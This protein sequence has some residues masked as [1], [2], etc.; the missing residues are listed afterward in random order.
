VSTATPRSRS[1]G[2]L[3]AGALILCATLAAYLPALHGGFVWDDDAHVTRPALRSLDGLRRIWFELGATQQYYPLL[4]SAF[5]VEHRLWGD[6]VAG[7]HLVNILLHAAAACLVVAIMRRLA[8]PGAWLAGFIFALHPV[9]VESVAWIS[10][11]KNTLSAV[12]CLGAAYVYIGYDGD[13]RPAR[14]AL[15]LGLFVLALLTKTVTATLPA[16]LLV[17]FCWRR[18]RLS[19][20]RDVMPLLPWLAIGAAAG[21]L[22]A[23]VERS[24]IAAEGAAPVL[25]WPGR[26]LL[27]G[28]VI[29]FY[30]GKLA[31]PADLMFV[32]PH[33]TV[34][35][36]EA[37]QYLFPAAALALVAGLWI[38]A[39][40]AQGPLR[41]AS[42]AA[43]AGFLIF[44]GT[45]FPALGFFNAFPFIYSYVADHFQYL[46]S[47][48]II[49]PASAGLALAAGRMTEESSRLLARAGAIALLA[50]LGVLTWLQSGTYRDV[51]TL[52]LATLARNPDCWMAHA[53]LGVAWSMTPGRTQDAVAEFNEALRLNPDDAEAH[54]D[55]GAVLSLMPGRQGD[56]IAQYEAAL[57][58]KPNFAGAHNNLG[59]ALAQVPGRLDEA[60]AHYEEAI[61]LEPGNAEAHNNLAS[62]WLQAPGRLEDAYAQCEEALRL[63]PGYA[64]AH[65][66]L[67][68][69]LSRM[70]GRIE[71]AV[72]QY[73]EALQLKSDYAEAH[74]NLANAWLYL[75]G[76][77]D[78]AIAQ[79]REALRLRPDLAEAHYNL[80]LALSRSPAR[81]DEAIAQ[82]GE[83]IRLRPDYAEAH[84]DLGAAL[85]TIPG[86]M[87]DAVAQYQEALRLDPG[88]APGWRNLGA[89][90]FNQGDVHG[91]VEAFREDVRLQPDSADAHFILG[92]AL[93]R[94]S[95]GLDEA[96]AQYR[97]ALRLA[98]GDPAAQR[99]LEAALQ[100]ERDG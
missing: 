49:V 62:A 11:Q 79:Y 6:S 16:A 4:H 26:F 32:Y 97:E 9:N 78:D 54:N 15:A 61:R 20:R 95:G 3:A 2:N 94:L 92:L 42:A 87:D 66:N 7:Y 85:S 88:Y 33:W 34:D 56:A 1:F 13:R 5:W 89:A 76:R 35:T 72:A 28:R 57:R 90:R 8:L 53:N 67:G 27:A 40:R 58:L 25:A 63:D 48:G 68:V 17:I 38:L 29:W 36:A 83:A 45:L 86:R 41:G 75:P 44:A 70:P 21:L 93:S 23:W 60:V 74:T 14:Y 59:H 100:R 64:L 55:L 37:W 19:W 46:A 96:I 10:E 39:V 31:W 73:Q 98:P 47:L 51:Q 71:D 80:G 22:T 43:L 99:A 82:Y 18:G 77:L 12:F 65:Y 84:N 81:L 30:L 50:T 24:M 69:A 52:Y 91:A